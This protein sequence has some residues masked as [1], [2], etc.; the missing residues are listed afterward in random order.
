MGT[1]RGRWTVNSK[2]RTGI[3]GKKKKKEEEDKGKIKKY[4]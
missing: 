4:L 2:H 3:N 1:K